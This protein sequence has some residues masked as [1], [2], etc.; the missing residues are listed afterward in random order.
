MAFQQQQLRNFFPLT[1]SKSS[2]DP[3]FMKQL[4]VPIQHKSNKIRNSRIHSNPSPLQCSSLLRTFRS[5]FPIATIAIQTHKHRG[6]FV[7][8]I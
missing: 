8:W 2:P 6:V 5:G 4:T 7:H 1:Q 3:N